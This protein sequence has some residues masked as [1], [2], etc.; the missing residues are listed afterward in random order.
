[1]VRHYALTRSARKMQKNSFYDELVIFYTIKGEVLL[2]ADFNA[3]A[4]SREVNT[5]QWDRTNG[6]LYCRTTSEKI[7]WKYI[8]PN[9]ISFLLT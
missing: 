2:I 5:E 8:T 4:G 9:S 1:M 7:C 6:V 3:H